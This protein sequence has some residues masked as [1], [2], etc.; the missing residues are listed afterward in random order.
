MYKSTAR[1]ICGFGTLWRHVVILL[2]IHSRWELRENSRWVLS[3]RPIL[4]RHNWILGNTFVVS[5]A[6][7]FTGISFFYY[8]GVSL[9]CRRKRNGVRNA[10]KLWPSLSDWSFLF[11]IN[12]FSESQYRYHAG[13]PRLCYVSSYLL[14][15]LLRLPSF[16]SWSHLSLTTVVR[17]CTFLWIFCVTNIWLLDFRNLL[18]WHPQWSHCALC[19]LLS[20]CFS[21]ELLTV[22]LYLHRVLRM[23]R[24]ILQ[25]LLLLP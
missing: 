12:L 8:L 21:L 16:F 15:G 14:K 17:W 18:P 9:I 19:L 6:W 24:L 10:T 7:F 3:C 11:Y 25:S 4:I 20:L 13:R 23:H 22:R 5:L 1:A 2:L